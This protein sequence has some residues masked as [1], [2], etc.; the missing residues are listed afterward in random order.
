MKKYAVAAFAAVGLMSL[1]VMAAEDSGFYVGAGLGLSNVDTDSIEIIEG[2]SYKFDDGSTAWKIFGGWRMNKYIS[3]EL[4]YFDTGTLDDEVTYPIDVFPTP[5]ATPGTELFAKTELNLSGWAP[6]IIGT[7]PIGIFELSGKLG[8]A[9]YDADIDIYLT[10]GI[11]EEYFSDSESDDDFVWGVG[12]GVTLFDHL[13][14]KIEYEA[15]E[16]SDA[17]ADIWWLTGAWRF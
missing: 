2:E 9:F 8:Y 16:V 11:D 6:Y 1:P 12:A 5:T 3:F 14:V 4:A 13:N 7:Y 15:I 17:N 10:D